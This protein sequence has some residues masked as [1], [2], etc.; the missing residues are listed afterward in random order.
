MA[1]KTF[2]FVQ[3]LSRTPLL[4]IPRYI[5]NIFSENMSKKEIS[6][7]WKSEN[8]KPR[9]TNRSP[10]LKHAPDKPRMIRMIILVGGLL[11]PTPPHPPNGVSGN[12]LG[13]SI[14]WAFPFFFSGAG[15]EE[16]GAGPGPWVPGSAPLSSSQ[17]PHKKNGNAQ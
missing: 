5:T 17:A 7:I 10:E 16:S 4:F 14:Y 9:F 13:V 6:K 12:L 8:P 2:H 11:V 3:G 1:L 15:G